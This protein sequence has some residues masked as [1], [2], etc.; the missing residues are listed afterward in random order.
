MSYQDGVCQKLQ[1]WV[2]ICLRCAE[3]TVDS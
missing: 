3:K 1:N 2:K